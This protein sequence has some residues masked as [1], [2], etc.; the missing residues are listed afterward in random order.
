MMRPRVYADF[1]KLDDLDRLILIT[2]GSRN[3][4][5]K[6]GTQLKSG[7]AVVFYD[8]DANEDGEPDDLEADGTLLYD[9]A[10]GHWVGVYDR[11]SLRH[12][13]DRI[14]RQDE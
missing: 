14:A 9:H 1:M 2:I 5:L 7:M 10:A 4:L 12:A 3:D 8:D 6:L 11:S 13:S